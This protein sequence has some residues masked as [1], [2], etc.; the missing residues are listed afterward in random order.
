MRAKVN[1]HGK[2][3]LLFFCINNALNSKKVLSFLLIIITRT[4]STAQSA[5]IIKLA[6]IGATAKYYV[7]TLKY[8]TAS[9]NRDTSKKQHEAWSY[10]IF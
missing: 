3:K 5:N 4:D 2:W 7:F 10:Y 9:G 8:R 6:A 1:D